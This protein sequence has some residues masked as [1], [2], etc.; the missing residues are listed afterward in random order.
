[1]AAAPAIA[2]PATP[3]STG[4]F[5][6][7]PQAQKAAGFKLMKPG[8]SYGLPNVGHIVVSMCEVPGKTS[9]RIVSVSYGSII[10]KSFSLAQDNA[11]GPC[12]SGAAGTYLGTYK[13]HGATAHMYGY[14]GFGG[15]PPCSNASI[16]IWLTWQVKKVYFRASSHDEARSNLVHFA[17]VLKRT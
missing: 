15:A 3:A 10:K 13:I 6:T 7:W 2:A 4:T 5:K 12:F 9:K 17:S 8:T 1:M 14:C 11:S 16:E